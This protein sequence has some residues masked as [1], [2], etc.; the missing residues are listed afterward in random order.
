ME[1]LKG[2]H[3]LIADDDQYNIYAL[4]AALEDY[5]M[6][7]L[8]ANNGREAV[9]AVCSHGDIDIVLMDIMMPE[10]D[11]YEAMRHIRSDAAF[12]DLPI[13]ALTA[14]AMKGDIEKCLDAGA[15]D[16]L[17]KPIDVEKLVGMIGRLLG[18][19]GIRN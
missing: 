2:R 11:G 7:L 19:N 18:G 16:Y 8:I 12:K 3:V 5:G 10:M 14:K 13:V 17:S 1:I 6:H 9:D 15:T 4:C